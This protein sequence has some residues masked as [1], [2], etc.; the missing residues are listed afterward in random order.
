ML[1]REIWRPIQ[2]VNQSTRCAD[3]YIDFA[4]TALQATMIELG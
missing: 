1:E 2:V 4:R 3:E